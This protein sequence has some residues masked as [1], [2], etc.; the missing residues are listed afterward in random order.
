MINHR[1]FQT[2]AESFTESCCW[3]FSEDSRLVSLF[4]SLIL[5]FDYLILS[6]SPRLNNYFTFHLKCVRLSVN[7]GLIY[8][9]AYTKR[10]L[11]IIGFIYNIYCLHCQILCQKLVDFT[12]IKKYENQPSKTQRIIFLLKVF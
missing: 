5:Y 6:L 12:Q 9:F 4:I 7:Q 2:E 8:I 1:P 10:Y 11:K 3:N